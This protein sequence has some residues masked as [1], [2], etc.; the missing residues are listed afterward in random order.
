MLPAGI[1]K[2]ITTISV[3][4]ALSMSQYAARWHL[5]AKDDVLTL[6]PQRMFRVSTGQ[7]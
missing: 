6:R 7:D 5:Y 4:T 1:D 2:D 3:N